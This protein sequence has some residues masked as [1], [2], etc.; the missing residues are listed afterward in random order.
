MGFDVSFSRA[1][2]KRE[3]LHA[4]PGAVLA[5]GTSSGDDYWRYT[6]PGADTRM[7]AWSRSGYAANF[8][9]NPLNG[10]YAEATIGIGTSLSRASV[11][12]NQRM[13]LAYSFTVDEDDLYASAPHAFGTIHARSRSGDF[14]PVSGQV[15]RDWITFTP[16]GTVT[17]ATGVILPIYGLDHL[18][19]PQNLQVSEA[20]LYLGDYD[21]NRDWVYGSRPS[22]ET[23]VYS[24]SGVPNDS[25][26]NLSVQEVLDVEASA[27]DVQEEATPLA[28]GDSSGQVGTISFTIPDPDPFVVPNNPIVKY[29]PE[30]LLDWGVRLSDTRKGFTLGDVSSVSRNSGNGTIQ[31]TAL[32]RLGK[33]NVYNVQANPVV[34]TLQRAFEYYLGLSQ[35]TLN[36]LVDPTISSRPVVFPGWEGELWFNLK[37]MAAALQCDISFVS[38]IVVVRPLRKREATRG[39]DVDRNF[40]AGGGSLA[41]SVEIYQY[42]NRAITNQLVYPPGGWTED[43]TVINV[44]SGE[45]VE[46]PLQLSAS[47]VSIQQP[48]M[49]TFVS[50]HHSSSSVFTVVGDDGLPISPAAWSQYGGSL[51]VVINPDTTSLTVKIQAPVGLPNRDGSAIEVYSISLSADLSTGRYSTLRI[52]GTGVSY[53]KQIRKVFTGVGP[54]ETGT[55]VGVTIDNPFL[56][57]LEE[58]SAAGSWAARSFSGLSTSISGTV[59]AINKRGDSGKLAYLSYQVDQTTN[60]G[61][62]YLQAQSAVGSSTYQ[63]IQDSMIDNVSNDFENQAFGNV[64]GARV[65]DKRSQRWYRIRSASLGPSEIQFDAE[66]D[67]LHSDI[68]SFRAAQT[69]GQ[70]QTMFTGYTYRKVDLM[71]LRNA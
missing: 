42:N 12:P 19:G 50:R 37:Q 60:A 63:A 66:D 24:W 58:V 16:T 70:I 7:A 25:I 59:T 2:V 62:T 32:T 15:Y 43:V 35:A 69:Y 67:L 6:F 8:V 36:L 57:T 28:A 49:Q 51:Q 56:S 65:W 22:S 46:E 55:D 53:D 20:D 71:G 10:D 23:A 29:G 40:G 3:N 64:N 17:S 27:F 18:S 52:V 54:S 30:W 33:L 47:V 5:L 39:R 41:Q 38:G 21:P 68:Q 44:N 13:T 45:Y 61:R 11:N 48:V 26:S 34:D 31:I 14:S 9:L 4:R 1:G